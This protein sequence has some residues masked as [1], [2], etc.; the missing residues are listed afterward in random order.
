MHSCEQN[1]NFVKNKINEIL[2]RKQLKSSPKIIAVTKTFTIDKIY[3]LLEIGHVHFGENKMQEAEVKWKNLKKKY[4]NLQLHMIGQLQ[5]N[6]AKK[7]VQ[8]FDYIH[9][10]DSAKLASK[11]SKYEKEMNKK[12]KLF[13]Q[14][15]I[16]EEKNKSGIPLKDVGNFFNYCKNELSL[17]VIG[18]MCL[19][20]LKS[21]PDKYFKVLKQ[22]SDKLNLAQLSMGMSADYDQ[23]VLNGSTFLRLGTAIFGNRNS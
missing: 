21:D 22:C 10:L 19:P 6:K 11:I 18:L 4:K 8:L 14:V 17:N 9:S 15:N 23:A 2:Y 12:I 16:V 13:I 5:S 20:P 1:L 3:P 7:A